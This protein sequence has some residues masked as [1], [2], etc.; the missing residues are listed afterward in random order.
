MVE[1]TGVDPDPRCSD[2][3][4][5]ADR[6]GQEPTA[7]TAPD[8]PR[9]QP[10]EGDLDIVGLAFEFEVASWRSV[11]PGHPGFQVV[12]IHPLVPLPGSPDEPVDP[13][14]LSADCLV[15]EAVELG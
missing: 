11:D 5:A 14:P 8:E 6:F 10:E 9:Q 15:E 1:R 7:E 4:G 3:P 12:P 2:R 13:E